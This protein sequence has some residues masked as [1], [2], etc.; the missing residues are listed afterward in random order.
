MTML[1]YA[2]LIPV[3]PLIAMALIAMWTLSKFLMR[4]ASTRKWMIIFY[5]ANIGVRLSV[6]VLEQLL[7]PQPQPLSRLRSHQSL[8]PD[9]LPSHH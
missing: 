7:S 2:W 8:T 3:F 4:K 6:V 1:S 9:L 5:G